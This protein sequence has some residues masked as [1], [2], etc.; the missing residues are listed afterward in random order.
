LGVFNSY[1]FMILIL[2]C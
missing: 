2:N 1:S